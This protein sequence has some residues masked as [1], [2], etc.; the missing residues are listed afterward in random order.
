M[1][2]LGVLGSWNGFHVKEYAAMLARKGEA[3]LVAISDDEHA[4]ASAAAEGLNLTVM[5][6]QELLSD[7]AIAGVIVTAAPNRAAALI[8]DA[9]LAGK[10]VLADK[11]I[12]VNGADAV[13]V[14][15]AIR[16]GQV[17]FALDLPLAQKPVC[18]AAKQTVDSGRLGR[19]TGVHIRNAHGGLLKG[20]LPPHFIED[21]TGLLTDIGLH[22]IYMACL[23]L[24]QPEAVTAISSGDAASR[25][26]ETAVC[27][28][29]FKEGLLVTVEMGYVSP[30]SPFSLELFGTEGMFTGG[31]Y[32]GSARVK[33]LNDADWTDLP[34]LQEDERPLTMLEQWLQ[35]IETAGGERQAW[36][37]NQGIVIGRVL[38]AITRSLEQSKRVSVQ[39]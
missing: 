14:A 35:D 17:P 2:Q 32:A 39:S 36:N 6:H 11:L 10:A 4:L 33:Q 12:A 37:L 25:T 22:G 34:L 31:G 21:P 28:L 26:P 29:E 13:R 7:P 16:A 20:M 3:K 1:M 24:G 19:L 38:E 8:A 18:L 5:S 15:E 9:V 23:L 27:V 30:V